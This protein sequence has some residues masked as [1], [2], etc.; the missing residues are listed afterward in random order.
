M[1][2]T[3][4]STEDSLRIN[5]LM[6]QNP[7]AIRIDESRLVMHALTDSGEVSVDLNPL[8]DEQ[9]YL[10]RVKALLS[11]LV[12]GSPGGY[13]VFL[14]R[15]TRMGQ[16]RD[17]NL[18]QMLLLGESEAVVAVAHA[19]GL[20]EPLGRRAWWAMPDADN[21]RQMLK[22]QV[23]VDSPLG[24]ELAGFLLE[25]LPFEEDASKMME[26]VKLLLQ[27]GLIEQQTMQ[28]LW[29]R[30]QMKRSMLVG[31]LHGRPDELPLELPHHPLLAE[32]QVDDDMGLLLRRAFSPAGQAFLKTAEQALA[33]V[34]D[35]EVSISLFEA[36]ASYFSMVKFSEQRFR[37]IEALQHSAGLV[38]LQQP[39]ALQDAARAALL[40]SALTEEL[41]NPIFAKTDAVGSGLRRKIK[42]VTD[43]VLAQLKILLA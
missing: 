39:S 29:Q 12:M 8:C 37:D 20:D 10:R 40:M 15:L 13:P 38:E 14:K 5:V 11:E 22:R 26:S 41:L 17:V 23:I 9:V 31:F 1:A 21:A 2:E 18:A 42:P 30:A 25:F 32:V 4:L 27:P 6:A 19:P 16:T 34:S 36:I 33:R 24:R 43:V 35:Q 28:Q 3:D 7:R